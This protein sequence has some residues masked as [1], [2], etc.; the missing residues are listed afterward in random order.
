MPKRKN[1]ELAFCF[2]K[3]QKDLPY[4]CLTT[5]CSL[6]HPFGWQEFVWPL[7]SHWQ[8]AQRNCVF[9]KQ[10]F[11]PDAFSPQTQVIFLTQAVESHNSALCRTVRVTVQFPSYSKASSS[12][13]VKPLPNSPRD[14]QLKSDPDLNSRSQT[15]SKPLTWETLAAINC[16]NL[17]QILPS[18]YI[19][20]LMISLIN[21]HIKRNQ[22][23]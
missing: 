22:P 4:Q 19:S 17:K 11:Q 14:Q 1:R 10:K 13:E 2:L 12:A 9:S 16:K 15:K 18:G 20:S 23:S 8:T 5:T 3:L 6:P 7:N 21:K